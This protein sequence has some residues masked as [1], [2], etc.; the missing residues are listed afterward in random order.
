MRD[1]FS[2]KTVEQLKQR[3]AFI[4]ANPKC[5]KMTVGPSSEA[6]DKVIYFGRAAHICGA[7]ENGPRYDSAMSSEE[8]S[9]INN[10]IY[11][12]SN[13]A[14]MVDDNNGLDFSKKDLEI[15]RSDHENW[16]RESL[17]KKVWE[18]SETTV[19]TNVTSY[20]QTGGITA[21]QV[22]IGTIPRR[23]KSE[24]VKL[25][26]NE[27][28]KY[29]EREIT[30]RALFSDAESQSMS[31]LIKDIFEKA[32][33]VIKWYLFEIPNKPMNNVIL[34]V[35]LSDENSQTAL[36]I[37]NWL[38]LNNLNVTAELVADDKGYIIFVG[39]NI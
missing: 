23:I 20:N 16:V 27:I 22:N 15:W 12:C 3:A 39:Q 2:H 1:N 24:T 4:C 25:F 13:C 5:K 29:P 35:P 8:R 10:A 7:A 37:Y 32:G 11:L 33:W 21:N 34:G 36:I 28:T 26:L 31:I 38:N 30:I 9:N 14:D 18:E 17:N 19:I 6:D